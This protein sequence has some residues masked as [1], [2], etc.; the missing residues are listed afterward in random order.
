MASLDLCQ[1]LINASSADATTRSHAELFLDQASNDQSRYGAFIGALCT[2]FST[3]GKPETSRQMAG[4]YLKN[5]ITAKSSQ[6]LN[7]KLQKW[8]NWVP[9]DIKLFIKNQFITALNSPTSVIRRTAAQ[10]CAAYGVVELRQNRWPELIPAAL[11]YVTTPETV[12]SLGTK[13][14]A[15][16]SLGYLCE[17]LDVGDIEDAAVNQILSTIIDGMKVERPNEMRFAATKALNNS[18]IYCEKNFESENERH[19]IM[20]QI[21]EA[22]RCSDVKTRAEAFRCIN[23]VGEYYYAKLPQYASTLFELTSQA[24]KTDDPFVGTT[25]LEFWCVICEQ[26][27]DADEHNR[28]VEPSEALPLFSFMALYTVAAVP[29]LL[30]AMTKQD[31]DD[32]VDWGIAKAASICLRLL[33]Q[34]VANSVVDQV[35]PFITGNINSPNWRFKEAA[36]MAFGSILDGPEESLLSPI[37]ASAMSPLLAAFQDSNPQVRSTTAWTIGVICDFHN[38]ALTQEM[39]LPLLTT[40]STA[41]DDSSS[42]VVTQACY[43]IERFSIACEGFKGNDSNPLS[44]FMQILVTKLLLIASKQDWATT[45]VRNIAFETIGS[46]VASSASDMTGLVV[47]LLNEVLSRLEATFVQHIQQQEQ[48]D[49]QTSLCSVL[50]NCIIR[51]NSDLLLPYADNIMKLLYLVFQSTNA[52]A[53]IEAFLATSHLVTKIDPPYDPNN[54]ART[55]NFLRYMRHGFNDILLGGLRS[56]DDHEVC[57]HA[58][59][60][61]EDLCIALGKYIRPYTDDIMKCLLELLQSNELQRS[62]KPEVISVFTEIA[63]ALLTDFE[64]YLQKVIAILFQAGSIPCDF[65]T[66]DVEL[67]EFTL[68]LKESILYAYD[69]I[70]LAFR[71]DNQAILLP[72]VESML[73]LVK[74][75]GEPSDFIR[76]SEFQRQAIVLLEDLVVSYGNQLQVQFRDPTVCAVL[77]LASQRIVNNNDA[78]GL[79]LANRVAQMMQKLC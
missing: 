79:A 64:V 14:A 16:E 43:V 62:V 7:E 55:P 26:E 69:G 48:Q 65:N 66:D 63:N 77:T 51:L 3:E 61:L 24:I 9:T 68:K 57:S 17:E 50:V 59:G 23:T 31:E 58:I 37:V 67:I 47:G 27:K 36:V 53:Q 78:D 2:E 75:A 34:T 25:A 19:A 33:A 39:V 41:L 38:E 72:V 6:I 29:I 20:M 32:D 52:S 49:I 4:L 76:D 44:A 21:C 13:I 74:Q 46:L 30:E 40:I 70:L 54:A 56:V 28:N 18:L 42:I 15:L 11:H 45:N 10:N 35:M 1:V 71:G 5:M 22:T 60:L 12:V 8:E 73:H